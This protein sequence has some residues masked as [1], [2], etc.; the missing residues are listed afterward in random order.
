MLR[1]NYK[2]CRFIFNNFLKREAKEAVVN[3]SFR[4]SLRTDLSVLGARSLEA[5]PAS[6]VE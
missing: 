2:F 4:A 5:A 6:S 3:S 1:S